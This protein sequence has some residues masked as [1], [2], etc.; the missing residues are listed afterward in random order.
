MLSI[1]PY[2]THYILVPVHV[3]ICLFL[4]VVVLLQSGRAADLASAFGGAPSQAN[5]AA[6][7]S[8]DFI[9]RATR[10]L[11]FTFM[12]TSMILAATP[13]TET[14][15]E[16]LLREGKAATEA[17]AEGTAATGDATTPPATEEP[18]PA[19]QPPPEAPPSE[20]PPAPE[21]GDPAPEQP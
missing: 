11:A 4:I 9:K 1:L 3:M 15:T 20:V 16:R 12:V 6:M 18:A 2:W 7:S 8:E 14:E 21:G 10:Y 5:L 17:P 19:E 13:R